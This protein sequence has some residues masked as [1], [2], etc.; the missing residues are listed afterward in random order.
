MKEND[1]KKKAK[2]S[3]KRTRMAQEGRSN[4]LRGSVTLYLDKNLFK[5]FSAECSSL[6]ESASSMVEALM[7]GFLGEQ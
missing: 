5:R 3:G 6:N 7:S 2:A 1:A 4:R